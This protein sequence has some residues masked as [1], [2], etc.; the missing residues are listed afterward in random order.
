MKK[1]E[2]IN[3]MKKKEFIASSKFIPSWTR[4]TKKDWWFFIR[5]LF[6][7]SP[8]LKTIRKEAIFVVIAKKPGKRFFMKSSLM[9]LL[10]LH[11]ANPNSFFMAFFAD[12]TD[13]QGAFMGFA[14]IIHHY[15]YITFGIAQL[16]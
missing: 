7:T 11:E 6:K 4:V 9:I 12:L 5:R 1:E 2:N 15:L 3:G 16:T 8:F 10:D 14:S 13:I